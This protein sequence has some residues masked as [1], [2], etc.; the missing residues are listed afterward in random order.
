MWSVWEN[1]APRKSLPARGVWIEIVN[2]DSVDGHASWSL[3]ARGVWIEI[4][5]RLHMERRD[6]SLPARGVW[7]EIYY[8][9]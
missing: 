1:Q 3:P 4:L 2:G 8:G 5:M 9:S 7:I 6:E